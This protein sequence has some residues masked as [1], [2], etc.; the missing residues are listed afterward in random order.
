MKKL[1]GY[2]VVAVLVIGSSLSHYKHRSDARLSPAERQSLRDAPSETANKNPG[3]LFHSEFRALLGASGVMLVD[4]ELYDVG[5]M[6]AETTFWNGLGIR[7]KDIPADALSRRQEGGPY[8]DQYS[9]AWAVRRIEVSALF[10][11]QKAVC[12]ES[13]ASQDPLY[14]QK[15]HCYFL[16]PEFGGYTSDASNNIVGVVTKDE[17]DAIF[18]KTGEDATASL[19]KMKAEGI[20]SPHEMIGTPLFV[21]LKDAMAPF[22]DA[23]AV[24]TGSLRPQD[25][26]H[27]MIEN[28]AGG[29]KVVFFND[30][31]GG[32]PAML[33][34]VPGSALEAAHFGLSK[35]YQTIIDAGHSGIQGVDTVGLD[36]FVVSRAFQEAYAKA[37]TASKHQSAET[38]MENIRKGLGQ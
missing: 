20:L 2:G 15:F 32:S 28:E 11:N 30:A 38:I 6:P 13:R 10:R 33:G 25:F 34:T 14:E 29:W 17:R 16:V 36:P 35:Q 22:V 27:F 5:P 4:A 8:Y 18:K 37:L 21:R 12:D 9:G 19:A 1:I 31:E 3:P 26:P 24:K 7:L 23:G